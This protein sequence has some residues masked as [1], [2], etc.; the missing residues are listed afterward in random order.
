MAEA[1]AV[2]REPTRLDGGVVRGLRE[3]AFWL[4]ASLALLLFLALI[5]YDPSDRSFT[6]TGEPG[7]VGNLIGPAGA[8]VARRRWRR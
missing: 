4:L 1:T 3:G 8:W 2:R 5:T 6:Y 7:R